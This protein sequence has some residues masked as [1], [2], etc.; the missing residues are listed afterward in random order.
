MF[1][2]KTQDI[3]ETFLITQKSA[4]TICLVANANRS[5]ESAHKFKVMWIFKWIYSKLWLKYFHRFRT[6]KF[7]NIQPKKIRFKIFWKKL[8]IKFHLTCFY[9]D[10]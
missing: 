5:V 3:Y 1:N 2:E 6:F 8:F 10:K 9:V 4:H 7:Y